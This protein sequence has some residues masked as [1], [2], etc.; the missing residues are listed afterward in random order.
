MPPYL[1]S[2]Q[3]QGYLK[4]YAIQFDLYRHI[5]LNTVVRKVVRSTGNAKWQ[6]RL[7]SKNGDE[8]IDYDK[9]FFAAE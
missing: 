7:S 5:R 1:S 4:S 2:S 9:V 8:I 6:L 3:V